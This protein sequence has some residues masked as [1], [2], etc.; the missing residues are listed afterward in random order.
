ML[1]SEAILTVTSD[2]TAPTVV[3]VLNLSTTTVRVIFS[4]PVA[5][6][7]A[8]SPSNYQLSG[9]I[10]VSSISFTDDDRTVLLTTSPPMV[11]GTTYALTLSNIRDRAGTANLI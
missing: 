6:A 2:S 5:P 4:E 9:G 7:S 3:S 8:T 11:Y 10:S 1:S